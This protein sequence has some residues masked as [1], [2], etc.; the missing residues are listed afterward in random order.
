MCKHSNLMK[1]RSKVN[2]TFKVEEFEHQLF[3]LPVCT[4][5]IR[6]PIN[7][8]PAEDNA[9][10]SFYHLTVESYATAASEFAKEAAELRRENITLNYKT[11][12]VK[13]N[14]HLKLKRKLNPME[15][16]MNFLKKHFKRISPQ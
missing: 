14:R 10:H 13:K 1:S 2:G 12:V 8:Y 3:V 4:G 11:M 5:V 6:M 7:N 16:E 15:T 9:P